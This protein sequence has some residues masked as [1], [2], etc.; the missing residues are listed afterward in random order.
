MPTPPPTTAYTCAYTAYILS[1]PTPP[2]TPP[3]TPA[4]IDLSAYIFGS[5]SSGNKFNYPLGPLDE[6]G[7]Y[8]LFKLYNSENIDVVDTFK[9]VML[10]TNS[11]GISNDWSSNYIYKH[12]QITKDTSINE[13][14]TNNNNSNVIHLTTL[15]SNAGQDFSGWYKYRSSKDRWRIWS[16]TTDDLEQQI[17]LSII[18]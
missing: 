6:S 16:I 13:L 10:Q 2:P 17:K 8:S 11:Y 5:W 3:P 7:N 18:A 15:A 4:P 1:V 12:Q 14:I 9:H